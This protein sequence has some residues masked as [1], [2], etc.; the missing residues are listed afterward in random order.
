MVKRPSEFN[1]WALHLLG[2]M[3]GH[4]FCMMKLM[5]LQVCKLPCNSFF[6]PLFTSDDIVNYFW[7]TF[8]V[9]VAN[10]AQRAKVKRATTTTTTKSSNAIRDGILR[11]NTLK[12]GKQ[13]QQQ[14]TNERTDCYTYLCVCIFHQFQ[15]SMWP[16]L[17]LGPRMHTDLNRH[18]THFLFCVQI[19]PRTRSTIMSIYIHYTS[20]SQLVSHK[21]E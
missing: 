13:Q 15:P 10:Y 6:S 9:S 5:H 2:P 4:H 1:E 19:L 14:R 7:R 16:I 17:Y 12:N 8:V 20:T 3:C 11:F 18:E 21:L